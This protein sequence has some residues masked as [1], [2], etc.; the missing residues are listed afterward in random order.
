MNVRHTNTNWTA[1]KKKRFRVI[2]VSETIGKPKY[3]NLPPLGFQ[4]KTQAKY[5]QA[6]RL[7]TS[8]NNQTFQRVAFYQT[9]RGLVNICLRKERSKEA[10]NGK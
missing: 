5:K 8:V 6:R 4:A 7:T 10:R 3:K 2:H 9:K 1:K